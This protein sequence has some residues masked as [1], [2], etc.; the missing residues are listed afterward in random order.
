MAENKIELI[1]KKDKNKNDVHLDAMSLD[2]AQSFLALF[3]SL[4]KIVELTPNNGDAKIQITTGSVC[5]V[6]TG[7]QTIASII[8][9]F[10]LM[11]NHQSSNSDVIKEWRKMQSLF[12]ANG[13]EYEVNF[14]DGATKKKTSVL[15]TI[16]QARR[17]SVKTSRKTYDNSV[18]FLAGKLIEVGGKTP[19][20]HIDEHRPVTCNEENAAI[21][22]KDYLYKFIRVGVWSKQNEDGDV[23][24]ELCDVYNN[25]QQYQD[26][27]DFFDT[28]NS[29]SNVE[30]LTLIH[31]KIKNLLINEDFSQLRKLLLLWI[32]PS[33][34]IQTLKIILVITKSFKDDDRISAYR[35]KILDQFNALNAK[36]VRASKKKSNG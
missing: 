18:K 17:F 26:F 27:K 28:L 4:T 35:E 23:S 32:H 7:N 29:A 15:E 31:R 8:S 3:E 33:T 16:K 9:D 34:D 24:Y 20:I 19:N 30:R 36:Y 1:V 10:D 6:A 14:Y 11:V 21:A 22:A 5:A 12:I 13:L 2:A 25:Q